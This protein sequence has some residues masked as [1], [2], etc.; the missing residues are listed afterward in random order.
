M[1]L[2]VAFSS[3]AHAQQD[4]DT[5]KQLWP[6]VDFYIPLNEKFRLFILAA[7]TKAEET[8]EN[9]EGS[10]GPSISP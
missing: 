4:S 7:T 5:V 6:E 1:T 9:T 8:K 2:A 10:R 3:G